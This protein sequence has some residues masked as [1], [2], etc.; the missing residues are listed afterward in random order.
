L[1]ILSLLVVSSFQQNLY[2]FQRTDKATAMLQNDAWNVLS[3]FPWLT[4]VQ[5]Y[6]FSILD[7]GTAWNGWLNFTSLAVTA[8]TVNPNTTTGISTQ[9]SESIIGTN[10]VSFVVSFN[11]V[12]KYGATSTVSGVGTINYISNAFNLTRTDVLP[13]AE[14]GVVSLDLT[15]TTVTPDA[16]FPTDIYSAQLLVW[17]QTNITGNFQTIGADLQT[18]FTT[19]YTG[20]T[21]LP[22]KISVETQLPDKVFNLDLG[23]PVAPAYSTNGVVYALNGIPTPQAQVTK[24]QQKKKQFLK[25]LEEEKVSAAPIFDPTA[26]SSQ[27]YIEKAV[28]DYFTNF[29]STSNQLAATITNVNNPSKK[30]SVTMYYL[31][32]IYPGILSQFPLDYVFNVNVVFNNIAVTGY[33]NLASSGTVLATFTVTDALANVLLTWSSNLSFTVNWAVSSNTNLNFQVISLSQISSTLLTSPYGFVYMS[34]LEAWLDDAFV[35]YNPNSWELF[36]TPLSFS[37][38]MATVAKVSYD[39]NGLL[40]AG[41]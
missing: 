3:T 22:S 35:N 9:Y 5:K 16:N 7:P 18:A 26:G 24:L 4:S 13:A 41:N 25:M 21:P 6:S 23:W 12:C 2:L 15:K 37:S 20:K 14:T 38:L 27:V 11:Y 10:T 34:T 1:T 29:E 32:S 36:K 8:N 17:M 31:G 40:I 28:F 30:F 33:F 19:Y 39:G